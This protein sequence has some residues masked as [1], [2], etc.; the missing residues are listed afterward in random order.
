MIAGTLARLEAPADDPLEPASTNGR[1]PA[2]SVQSTQQDLD[3]DTAVQYGTAA[4]T[5]SATETDIS[6][7][8]E[9]GDVTII[10]EQF[11]G[12][13]EHVTDWVADVTGTGLV[14]VESLGGG[15]ELAFPLDLIYSQTGQFPQRLTVDIEGLTAAWG[16]DDDQTW[17]V[18]REDDDGTALAYHDDADHPDGANIGLGFQ[19]PY[20]NT[21]CRGVVYESGYVAVY[22]HWTEAVFMQF[23]ADEILPYC[24][25]EEGQTTL[26]GGSA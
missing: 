18:S 17:Y 3:G 16:L 9:D 12:R 11:E 13:E 22:S 10:T 2:L 24:H 25:A 6:A 4:G 1:M 21:G 7:I 5:V 26:G 20:R 14:C 19:R 8:A 23:V 15:D